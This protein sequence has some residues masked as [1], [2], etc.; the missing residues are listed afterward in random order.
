MRVPGTAWELPAALLLPWGP[1]LRWDAAAVWSWNFLRVR[2]LGLVCGRGSARG[3]RGLRT[4]DV[5]AQ[6]RSSPRCE[7]RASRA[8]PS[9]SVRPVDVWP[10]TEPRRRGGGPRR[11]TR[12]RGPS[13]MALLRLGD[14]GRALMSV[15]PS[16]S[17]SLSGHM[18]VGRVGISAYGGPE[19]GRHTGLGLGSLFA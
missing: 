12:P 10:L 16:S 15:L 18:E 3:G 19:R 1:S 2:G 11:A 6:G 17:V 7:A 5:R 14:Q 8:I 13:S 4:Q 9:A